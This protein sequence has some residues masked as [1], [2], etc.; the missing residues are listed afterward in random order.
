[1]TLAE[2]SFPAC[3]RKIIMI[4]KRAYLEHN[5][6]PRSMVGELT[7]LVV[8]IVRQGRFFCTPYVA[9]LS[10]YSTGPPLIT[11]D[12]DMANIMS[13][14]TCLYGEDKKRIKKAKM[15]LHVRK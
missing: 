2:V 15:D 5:S 7:S 10:E 3:P 8:C 11:A 1:M 12:L 4:S 13:S 6:S 14:R 9:S